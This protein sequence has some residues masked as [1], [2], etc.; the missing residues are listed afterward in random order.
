MVTTSAVHL[1]ERSSPRSTGTIE[2][3]E[4]LAFVRA[5]FAHAAAEGCALEVKLLGLAGASAETLAHASVD[6]ARL[7]YRGD[8][9][10]AERVAHS[11]IDSFAMT[12]RL[13]LLRS[14]ACAGS[15]AARAAV[16]ITP[17][18]ST[19]RQRPDAT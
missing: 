16:P 4:G 6:D 12:S 9:I 17:P 19:G 1:A 2:P 18:V 5:H 15:P 8:R 7:V 3:A 14:A 13:S 11:E 10:D